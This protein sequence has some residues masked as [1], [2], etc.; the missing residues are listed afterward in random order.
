LA[1]VYFKGNAPSPG[2]SLF[3]NTPATVHYVSGTT[4]WAPT[5]GG[6]PTA[7][8][9]SAATFSGN[10]GT[11]SVA[12][13]TYNVGNAY[14][15]LPTAT[16]ADPGYMFGGWR[17]GADSTGSQVTTSTLVPYVTTGHTLYAK[18][19]ANTYAVMFDA[20]GGI[21]VSPLTATYGSTYGTL[22]TPT[23]TGYAFTGWYTGAGTQVTV[24]T[25]VTTASD[26]TLYAKWAANTYTVAYN[27]NGS[28]DGSTA[29]SNHTYDTAQALNANG[30]SRMGYTFTGWATSSS[31]AVAYNS[32]QSVVNLA[33]AQGATV[34]LYAKWTANTYTVLFD[35]Q[36]GTVTPL[37]KTATYNSAYGTLPTPTR[38]G[39]YFVGWWT[40]PDG[41]GLRVRGA[42]VVATASD[43]TLY[44]KWVDSY[45]EPP[46]NNDVLTTTGSYDGY[47][48]AEETFETGT[49]P[50]VRGTLAVTVSTF[51][52]KLTAKATL[53]T[54]TASLSG[55]GWSGTNDAGSVYVTLAAKTGETLDLYVRQNRI[56]GTLSG[57]KTGGT[58]LFDG[59]RNRFADKKDAEAQT[60]LTRFKG[61]YTIVLDGDFTDAADE[62]GELEAV[63]RGFGYLTATV[64]NGGSAKVAGVL[65]D[66]TKVSHA[67]RAILFNGTDVHV[68]FF[69][70]LYSKAGWTGGLLRIDQAARQINP[71][72]DTEGRAL[73]VKPGKGPDGFV[74]ALEARGG[75]YSKKPV[76]QA[77]YVIEYALDDVPYSIGGGEFAEIAY[78]PEALDVAVAGV[79][80][81]L[82]KGKAPKKQGS[83]DE[84]YWY[85]YDGVNPSMSTLSFT[86]GT[87]LFKGSFKVYYDYE[88]ARGNLQHKA[89]SVPYAG[90]VLQGGD[91]SVPGGHGHCLVPDNDP[92]VKVYKLKHSFPVQLSAGP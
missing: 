8:W 55:K 82:A 92:A 77:G 64:G 48:Y 49:A 81:S 34:T 56:W 63:P 28:T 32:E 84:G 69:V 78:A 18:W 88:D 38:D 3:S 6:R 50:S 1:K 23:R 52:G 11:P 91:G 35:A 47:L 24:A 59:A 2:S 20:Q 4:G 61:Y 67:S 12:S 90:V 74:K 54:G 60:V 27:G 46:E 71:D 37:S 73:W 7:V 19:T 10:G 57:G 21:P 14:G 22:P 65:A 70:P 62:A 33:S 25:A 45:I 43:H 5:Y 30:Y 85:D 42:T 39:L 72:P 80:M 83:R 51:T 66:G 53:Q 29:N 79:K 87:G 40:G 68:P 15:E 9:T 58:L 17:T 36:G 13:R 86:A 75:W 41:S 44:A 76:L 16:H 89:V 31:G 26:H